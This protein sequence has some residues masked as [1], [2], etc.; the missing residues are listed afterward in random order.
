MTIGIKVNVS[1]PVDRGQ[2]KAKVRRATAAGLGDA[3]DELL[4][5]ASSDINSTLNSVLRHQ[6][7]HFRTQTKIVSNRVENNVI[8]GPWLEGTGSR[9]RTTRFKGYFTFRRVA[10]RIRQK[11]NYV[12]DRAITRALRKAGV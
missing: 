6:T 7:P 4:K 11:A 8:Y 1:G 12:T 5:M 3:E 10:S 2:W 9:N